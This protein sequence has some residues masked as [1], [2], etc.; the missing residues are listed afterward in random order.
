M[1]GVRR[2]MEDD[3]RSQRWL[4][5]HVVALDRVKKFPKFEQFVDG[6]SKRKQSPAEMKAKLAAMTGGLPKPGDAG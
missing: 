3:Q 1:R 5:W 6:Q 4:A 2:R